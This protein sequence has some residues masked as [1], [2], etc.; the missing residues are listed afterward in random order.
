MNNPKNP[1]DPI[2][3]IAV[4]VLLTGLMLFVLMGYWVV[5]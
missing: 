4:I 2:E 1:K 3:I 5:R